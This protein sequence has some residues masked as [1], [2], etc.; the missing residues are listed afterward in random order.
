MAKET[1][2]TRILLPLGTLRCSHLLARVVGGWK[3]LVRGEL[4]TPWGGAGLQCGLGYRPNWGGP[5]ACV[6]RVSPLVI[7]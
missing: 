1:E 5:I 3:L 4:Q 6:R 2:K 7:G